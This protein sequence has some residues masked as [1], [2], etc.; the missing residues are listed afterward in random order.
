[1]L[2][3]DD[4][5]K[6]EDELAKAMA[7]FLKEG[8]KIEVLPPCMTSEEYKAKKKKPKKNRR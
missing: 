3:G 7:K 8:G 2:Y 5:K 4:K 1:M 6:Q